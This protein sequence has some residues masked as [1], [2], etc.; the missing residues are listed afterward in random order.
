MQTIN[1]TP[2][3]ILLYTVNYTEDVK[4]YL[5]VSLNVLNLNPEKM[6]HMLRVPFVFR[7]KWAH[8]FSS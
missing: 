7:L 2:E 3:I 4:Y 8:D 5:K 6:G 1:E